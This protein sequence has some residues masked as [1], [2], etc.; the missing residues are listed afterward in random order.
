MEQ[1]QVDGRQQGIEEAGDY[2]DEGKRHAE[3]VQQLV[4]F[5]LLGI[6]PNVE[7]KQRRVSLP[8]IGG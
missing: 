2:D 6:S 4:R 8:H 3:V 5:V 1:L 7:E